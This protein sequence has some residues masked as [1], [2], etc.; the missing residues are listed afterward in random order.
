MDQACRR[1]TAEGKRPV[2]HCMQTTGSSRVRRGQIGW[3]SSTV[4]SVAFAAKNKAADPLASR[5][6]AYHTR[7]TA[8]GHRPQTLPGH[9]GDAGL[10]S[11]ARGALLLC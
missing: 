3:C 2:T 11:T 1:S 7:D 9:V 8:A 10:F 6:L 5:T 4:K